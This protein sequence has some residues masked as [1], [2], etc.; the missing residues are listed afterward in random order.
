MIS[1][2]NAVSELEKCHQ[3]RDLALDCYL[4][5]IRNMAFYAVELDPQTTG[6]HRKYLEDLASQLSIGTTDALSESRA[7]VRGLLREYRDH[8]SRRL[9]KLRQELSDAAVAL[10]R[11]LEALSQTDGDHGARLR[12]A[13]I[14][15]RS[16]PADASRTVVREVVSAAAVSIETSLEEVR[17]EH[18]LTVAQFVTEIRM[19]HH[20]IDGLE[21]AASI[22]KVTQLFNREQ[23]EERIRGVR[24]G[25]MS[26]L[27]LKAGGLGAAETQFGREVAEELTGA[28]TKR[29]RNSL[30]SST[31]IGRW[32]EELFM[33]MLQTEKPEATALAKRIS[34]SLAG[35]YA[36]LKAGKTVHPAIHLRIGVADPRADSPDRVLQWVSEF[37]KAG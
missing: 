25:K 18:Q 20:R 23:M 26:I 11:T 31:V 37:L 17:K 16:I 10:E 22:D 21:S 15:L 34:D 27:L 33:A 8:T 9:G 30:P 28:F 36:C 13:I 29:L 3:S 1:L 32:S 7:T 35:A 6:L 5:A 19:L 2:L 14:R 24:P 12:A 4:T